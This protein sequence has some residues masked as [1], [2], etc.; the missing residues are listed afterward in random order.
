MFKIWMFLKSKISESLYCIPLNQEARDWRWAPTEKIKA[1]IISCL[2]WSL[3]MK[4]YSILWALVS[5]SEKGYYGYLI[6][7]TEFNMCEG[8]LMY[9]YVNLFW[10][11]KIIYMGEK[12]I[13]YMKMGHML[14]STWEIQP[15]LKEVR[16]SWIFSSQNHQDRLHQF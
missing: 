8:K 3:I 10:K 6:K 1:Q 11:F 13:I 12:K 2:V 9:F 4:P 16:S 5:V 14:I 15:V 7:L